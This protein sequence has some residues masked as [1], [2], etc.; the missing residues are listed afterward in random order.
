MRQPGV[1]IRIPLG[2]VALDS[3]TRYALRRSPLEPIVELVP[4]CRACKLAHCAPSSHRAVSI[5]RSAA[6]HCAG[7]PKL[8]LISDA[9]NEPNHTGAEHSLTHL[10]RRSQGPSDLARPLAFQILRNHTG[11]DGNQD[12]HKPPMAEGTVTPDGCSRPRRH[13]PD[14]VYMGGERSSGE[15]V[16]YIDEALRRNAVFDNRG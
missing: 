1:V 7:C 12:R 11:E 8:P 10:A 9:K 5:G 6:C 15:T 16:S 3:P 13:Q 2:L 4:F 14:R